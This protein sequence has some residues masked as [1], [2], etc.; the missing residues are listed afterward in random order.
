MAVPI[1]NVTRRQVYAPSGSGGAGP[2]A[3]TF[4][5]LANTDIAVYK[6]DTLL[7]LTTHYTVTINSNG[8]G[9]VT[10]TAAGLAL[11]PTSPTQYAIV[12]NRTISRSTDFTTGGDFFAN[13]INDELDQQ[14]I[15]A[16]QNAEGLQR[17]LTAPQTDPTTI[18]MTL[19][20]AADRAN[21]T[22]AF[23]ANG[24]PTLGISAAD[25]ANALTYATNAANSATAAASS[26]SSASS[27]ASSAS[28]SASTASTQASNAS[29]SATSASNSASSASTSATNAASSASTASTQA[30]N[31]STSATNAASS[32][33][34]ASTSASNASTS[35]TNA[36]NS[37]SAAATSASN[38]ATSETNAAASAA[39]AASALDSFDDRY[40]GSKTSNPTLDN[41]GNALVTGALYYRSTAPIGMKVYDGA[42]WI[43]ASAAQQAALV[44]YEYVATAGQT[45]FSGAD[46]NSLTLSYIAGG[47]IVSLNGS[48]LR[49]GDDY[50]ATNGTSIVLVTAASLN[51]E[52]CA[53]AFSSFNV[54]N[55]YTQA[56]TDSL[57]AAKAPLASPA[58][59]GTPTA[60]T[61]AAA[62]NTTQLATTAFV[63]ALTGTSGITGF[64]NRIINGAMVIDQRNAGASVTIT[65]NAYTLDRWL[66]TV[67]A[68]SKF[69]VQQNAGSIT[70]PAGFTKY[71]GC[72]S[73][74]AYSIGAGDYFLMRQPVEGFNTADLGWGTANAQTITVS[75]RV[76]S[77]LTGT[78]GGALENNATN[79]S[80]P[81]SYTISAANT[82]ETKSITIAGDTSGT[83][84]TDN[85]IGVML[86]FGLGVGS[87]FSG[88]AGSWSSTRYFSATGATSV[89]GTNGATFYITGVQL[90]KG[91]T[92]TSFDYRPYGT[93]LALCQ[94][95]YES[96]AFPD[97]SFGISSVRITVSSSTNA[98][99]GGFN[100]LVPKRTNSPTVTLYSR[101]GTSGKTSLVSTGADVA[102]T[103]TANNIGGTGFWGV[104]IGTPPAAGSG[105][106][107][108]WTASA[109]L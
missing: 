92:A 90:E 60:P 24:D 28:S 19:P 84:A 74:S 14:T 35:A 48:I 52:L 39:S 68:S 34:S 6:E 23:D 93:E 69:S 17:A 98:F 88:T 20:K 22:L 51:D 71:L 101:N 47:L 104:S 25:V 62:T 53:Y 103:S 27:S 2:Y 78:F 7:T 31:A 67:S 77:S 79:R 12:G 105:I 102:G 1:S 89:V 41:D 8:T 44:T 108:G 46:A 11:S 64:K 73:L 109:E 36:S 91:S 75:F 50:T 26:A 15:F 33:S 81:F 87:T 42:Q 58:L 18:D 54:A 40:L 72:T 82:W 45:T 5:I 99:A 85:S 70:S 55:T 16:Q 49:P 97:A 61:A 95:Y 94:R 30:S 96:T 59:T 29:T 57:L 3:F 32:A 21:K 37:A 76:Y 43:E 100:Y 56:Q 13:T 86:A 80:Y 10:I 65:S 106:E 4:E 66:A 9:S 107:A 83:W 63:S 38:A